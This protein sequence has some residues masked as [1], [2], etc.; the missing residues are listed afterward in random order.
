MESQIRNLGETAARLL[1][2][3]RP[4]VDWVA[5]DLNRTDEIWRSF[6]TL[7]RKYWTQTFA[8]R[9]A[10]QFLDYELRGG[11]KQIFGFLF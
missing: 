2:E 3:Y 10:G 6:D 7:T 4:R 9:A 11:G 5:P 1:G 8:E